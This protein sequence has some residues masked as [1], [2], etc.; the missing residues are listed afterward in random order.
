MTMQTEMRLI[1]LG[2]TAGCQALF[3][4]VPKLENVALRKS[5]ELA[6]GPNYSY[7]KDRGD[8]TQLTDGV[9]AEGKGSLWVQKPTVGWSH[10]RPVRIKIDL[11]RREPIVG[12]SFST[13]AGIAG[14]RWPDFIFVFVSDDGKQWWEVGELV[15]LGADHARPPAEGYSVHR[16]WTHRL[17]AAGR[18]V[19]LVIWAPG[20]YCFCDEVE[21]YRGSP[22]LLN[23]ERAGPPVSDLRKRT[24]DRAM[25]AAFRRD[26]ARDFS[27]LRER[28]QVAKLDEAE[29]RAFERELASVEGQ[30][31]DLHEIT[32]L[33]RAI[34]PCTDAHARGLALQSQLWR[35]A[36]RPQFQVWSCCPWDP[37]QPTDVCVE[38]SPEPSVDLAMMRNEVRSAALNFTNASD[39]AVEVRVAVEGVVDAEQLI[40]VHEVAWTRTRDE[41]VTGSALPEA[42]RTDDGWMVQAPAG[43]TR[44]IW[45]SVHSRD[46]PSGPRT[47]R[48]TMTVDGR[49]V[50]S[51]PLRV[52]VAKLRMPDSLSLVWGGWDYS[53]YSNYDIRANNRE[54]AVAFLKKY[55]VTAPWASRFAMPF[56]RHDEN[57]VM[58]EPP[59]TH[60]MDA[61]VDRW[62][63]ARHYCV[64]VA[65]KEDLPDTPAARR[66]IA[67]WITFWVEH[68]SQRGIEPSRLYLLLVDEP[69][70]KAMDGRTIQYAK[71]IRAAQ[72]EVSI[73]IDPTWKDPTQA[74]PELFEVAN[75]IC[76]LRWRWSENR[77]H[78]ER[79]FLAQQRAGRQLAFYSCF[80]PTRH[81]DPYSYYRLQAWGCF[82]YGMVQEMFW[83]LCDSGGG[84]SW[85]EHAAARLGSTPQFLDHE[86]CTTS[87][88]MEAIRAGLYDHEYLVMLRDRI[89]ELERKGQRSNSVSQAKTLLTDGLRQV[90]DAEGTER[91]QWRDPKDR[92]VADKMRGHILK[93]LESLE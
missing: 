23:A 15:S 79:A 49:R 37:A 1:L 75:V 43:M 69:H 2:L 18:Y 86:G 45:L 71:P 14:V 92:T 73:W 51:V 33:S 74:T 25:R 47:G 17:R 34:L 31:G 76:A 60:I 50:A 68:L 32:G 81:Y 22:E 78:Y 53:D 77:A 28:A 36:G 3:G 72:P 42:R 4:Q 88:E 41:R 55:H 11:G 12:V 8:G 87:K 90:L 7:C 89:A 20:P 44:Q 48:V 56:G 35:A 66:R 85:N 39:R 29:R 64:F 24:V 19:A 38:A 13:A 46:L 54:A 30:I 63:G 62:E 82:R 91:A 70:T 65:F 80:V 67:D 57:G 59:R 16:F 6:P 10:R 27:A 52:H 21:V 84:S 61:W 58:V 93:A 40:T 9:Y 5:Y 83:C 26:I